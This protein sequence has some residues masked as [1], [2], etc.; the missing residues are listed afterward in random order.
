MFGTLISYTYLQNLYYYEHWVDLFNSHSN[1]IIIISVFLTSNYVL[2]IRN[3]FPNTATAGP[4]AI[5]E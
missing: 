3:H 4:I 5:A 2:C 1:S